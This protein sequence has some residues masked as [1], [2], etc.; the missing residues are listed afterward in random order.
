ML[1]LCMLVICPFIVKCP[2]HQ[3]FPQFLIHKI[4]IL[5]SQIAVLLN[6]ITLNRVKLLLLT[7][8][9]HVLLFQ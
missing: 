3:M 8:L 6:G 5:S 2:L 9:L 7:E 4:I 1:P